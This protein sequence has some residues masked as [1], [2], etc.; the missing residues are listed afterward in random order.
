MSLILFFLE[1]IIRNTNNKFS[2][3]LIFFNILYF[4]NK[5]TN[6]LRFRPLEAEKK[7]FE[8][9]KSTMFLQKKGLTVRGVVF[10]ILFK[11]KQTI[12]IYFVSK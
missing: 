2:P 10:F 4:I 5:N 1:L 12:V 7:Q 6:F 9:K 3:K 11:R 8:I